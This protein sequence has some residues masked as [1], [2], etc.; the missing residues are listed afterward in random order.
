MRKQRNKNLH[1]IKR[2]GN[3]DKE[4]DEKANEPNQTETSPNILKIYPPA[5]VQDMIPSIL[6]HGKGIQNE[7]PDRCHENDGRTHY[8]EKKRKKI[9]RNEHQK[10][11]THTIYHTRLQKKAMQSEWYK[12]NGQVITNEKHNEQKSHK[13][14][15]LKR[16][17]KLNQHT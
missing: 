6:Q 2:P 16:N 5:S 11:R 14:T 13:R 15:N 17:E 3:W 8:K 7:S 10:A 9:N 4:T 12:T 1:V